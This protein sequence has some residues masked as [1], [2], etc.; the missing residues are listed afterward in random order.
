MYRYFCHQ[1]KYLEPIR[2][3][4]KE[5]HKI[6]QYVNEDAIFVPPHEMKGWCEDEKLVK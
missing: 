5:D 1:E 6:T 4:P 3:D 2:Q